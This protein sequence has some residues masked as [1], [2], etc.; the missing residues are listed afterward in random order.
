TVGDLLP[1]QTAKAALVPLP[2][3]APGAP[4]DREDAFGDGVLL[5]DADLINY[6]YSTYDFVERASFAD[7]ED[8]TEEEYGEAMIRRSMLSNI[9]RS[10]DGSRFRFVAFCDELTELALEVDG[11]PVTRTAQRGMVSVNLTYD[12]VG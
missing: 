9:S 7:P 3:A 10:D 5:S 4:R 12:P 2:A 1:G 6:S 8:M 11:Q